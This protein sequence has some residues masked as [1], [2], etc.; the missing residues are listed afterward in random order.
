M[1]SP[2]KKRQRQR[3]AKSPKFVPLFHAGIKRPR[4]CV[5]SVT[6]DNP[7]SVWDLDLDDQ[8]GSRQCE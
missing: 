5:V 1:Q 2:Q 3:A 7:A 8:T 4:N 6:D